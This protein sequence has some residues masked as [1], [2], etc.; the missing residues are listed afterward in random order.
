MLFLVTNRVT[1]G[2]SGTPKTTAKQKKN[3]YKTL[4]FI[5]AVTESNKITYR[6]KTHAPIQTCWEQATDR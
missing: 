4:V 6:K 2:A 5:T 1:A 3:N